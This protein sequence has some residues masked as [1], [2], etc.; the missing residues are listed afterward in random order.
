MSF[1]D[2]HSPSAVCSPTRYGLLTGRYSWRTRQQ[3]SRSEELQ[4][5]CDSLRHSPDRAVGASKKMTA[6]YMDFADAG[7]RYTRPDTSQRAPENP[8]TGKQFFP[9]LNRL[10][11]S[12]AT[13][14]P[15]LISSCCLPEFGGATST[16]RIRVP[17]VVACAVTCELPA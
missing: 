7:L 16:S 11:T 9:L 3:S 8:H 4:R 6:G 12:P 13:A 17:S 14:S 15:S 2:A 1:T 5:C 10:V